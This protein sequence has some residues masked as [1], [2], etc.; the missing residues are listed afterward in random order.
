MTRITDMRGDLQPESSG[1]LFMSS[2]AGAEEAAS[3]SDDINSCISCDPAFFRDVNETKNY[4][5]KAKTET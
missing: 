4:E 2:L 3:A 1:W 5:T